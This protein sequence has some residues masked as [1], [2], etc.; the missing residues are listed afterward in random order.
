MDGAAF[1]SRVAT[2]R[3]VIEAAFPV[4]PI[5]AR[6]DVVSHACEECWEIRD[7]FAG[8]PWNAVPAETLRAYPQAL[9]L[10]GVRSH[11]YYLPAYLLGSLVPGPA[12]AN[13]DFVIY[14]LTPRDPDWWQERFAAMSHRQM[15][16]MKAWLELVLEFEDRLGID[17]PAAREGYARYWAPTT[18]EDARIFVAQD[19]PDG[20]FSCFFED[21]GACGWLYVCEIHDGS[22]R[23]REAIWIYD[24]A[25]D[26]T[27]LDFELRW[28]SDGTRCGLRIHGHYWAVADVKRSQRCSAPYA[29]GASP[30]LLPD[31]LDGL[32]E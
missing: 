18:G 25:V 14:D 27:P 17:E 19:S 3:G 1:Q 24:R 10:L 15:E 9:S 23:I 22:S 2:L 21:D 11:R 8:L 13:I 5:P 30:S 28:T 31:M 7:A 26:V 29:P 20:S 4:E 32:S 6:G 16:A 12:A